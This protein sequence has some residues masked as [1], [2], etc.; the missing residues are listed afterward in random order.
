MSLKCIFMMVMFIA[1]NGTLTS[2]TSSNVEEI[3]GPKSEYHRFVKFFAPWCGHCKKMRPDW[4]KLADEFPKAH[5]N[6]VIADVDCTVEKDLCS[7][8]NVE[9]FPTL[10][11]FM[12]NS[13]DGD[14]YSGNDRSLKGL[15]DWAEDK[16]KLFK[17]SIDNLEFCTKEQASFVKKMSKMSDSEK[18]SLLKDNDDSLTKM[19]K[20]HDDLLKSLQSQFSSSTE[21]LQSV[22][23]RVAMENGMVRKSM[24]KSSKDEL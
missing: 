14:D 1:V 10:K 24:S 21:K 6:V 18:S 12:P 13:E 19:Q 16:L 8:Y 11:Y 17:C 2:V 15:T 7:K 5:D 4:D 22:K 9:G 23:S 3:L 20:D